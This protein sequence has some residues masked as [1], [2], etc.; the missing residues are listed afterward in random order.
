MICIEVF[1]KKKNEVVQKSEKK[2]SLY[3]K[4]KVRLF[5]LL[6]RKENKYPT[7]LIIRTTIVS[8]LMRS[9]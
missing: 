8:H 2:Q 5:D 4:L 9:A 3:E 1:V 6:K 7:F